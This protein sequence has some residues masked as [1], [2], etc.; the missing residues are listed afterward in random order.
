ML[1]APLPII[2]KEDVQSILYQSEN[3]ANVVVKTDDIDFKL[4]LQTLVQ[5]FEATVVKGALDT[6]S[7]IDDVAK[8]C[9]YLGLVYTKKLRTII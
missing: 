5:N 2:R 9:K 8:P 4:G 1:L 7:D 6:Y 3:V